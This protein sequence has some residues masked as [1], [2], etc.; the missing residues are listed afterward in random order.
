SDIVAVLNARFG[1]IVLHRRE[2]FRDIAEQTRWLSLHQHQAGLSRTPV[3]RRV[4][5]LRDARMTGSVK[6]QRSTRLPGDG[7]L[8]AESYRI[9]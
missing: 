3:I 1:E 4:K 9:E 7:R 5:M 2:S 6:L 8:W